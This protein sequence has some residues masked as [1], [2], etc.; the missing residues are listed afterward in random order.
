MHIYIYISNIYTDIHK[1]LTCTCMY[2][3]THVYIG[4]KLIFFLTNSPGSKYLIFFFSPY[5][6]S[7]FSFPFFPHENLVLNRVYSSSLIILFMEDILWY[8]CLGK[9]RACNDNFKP[10]IIDL[11]NDSR[12][13]VNQCNSSKFLNIVLHFLSRNL[14][15]KG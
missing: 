11:Q 5:S 12:S 6:S 1:P 15:K 13:E 14:E 10:L 3:D 7:G 9:T 4:R 2:I 8:W